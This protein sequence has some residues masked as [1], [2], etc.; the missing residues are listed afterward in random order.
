[1]LFSVIIPVYNRPQEVEELLDSLTQQ[2]QKNFELV[3]V[4]DGSSE[5]CRSVVDRYTDQLDIRYFYKDNSGPGDSRNFGMAKAKGDYLLFFDSDCLIPPHYFETVESFLQQHPLDAYGGPDTAH[6]SFSNTQ[7]AI[8]YAMTSVITTGGVRGKENKLDNYQP[9]SFN[10][11]VSREVYEAVGG[12]GDI[13]PG[14]DPDLSYR[15]MQAGFSIGLIADA[16]VYH[17]RRIDFSKFSKQVYKFGVVRNVLMKWH[18]R[19][20]KVVYFFPTAFLLGSIALLLLAL[21]WHVVFLLPLLALLLIIAVDAL[22]KTGN[23]TITLM[24]IPATF[25]QLYNYGWGFLKGFW[26]IH[27]LKKPEREALPGFFFKR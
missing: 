26:L 13:H 5:D 24:A 4:E 6:E 25:I 11:G 17:K 1:M 12:Y 16:Y 9:R 3:I 10:M 7:K 14:E 8:N 2:T 27:V 20:W 21:L 23:L 19:S 18:P 15:I 22:V